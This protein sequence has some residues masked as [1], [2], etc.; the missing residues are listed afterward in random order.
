[1]E[2]TENHHVATLQSIVNGDMD[3][4]GSKALLAAAKSAV[5]ALKD[6]DPDL[7]ASATA[8]GGLLGAA[9]IRYAEV[10]KAARG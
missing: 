3:S 6:S 4:A 5:A 1:M 9:M 7:Y 10:A 8:K 2:N